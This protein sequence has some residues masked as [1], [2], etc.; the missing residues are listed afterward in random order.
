MFYDTGTPVAVQELEFFGNGI[1][2]ELAWRLMQER[3]G[4]SDVFPLIYSTRH[5]KNTAFCA[6]SLSE[7]GMG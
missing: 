3:Y 7:T 6:K 2:N 5:L 1:C 4:D